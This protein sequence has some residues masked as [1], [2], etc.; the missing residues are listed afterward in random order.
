[1]IYEH[2]NNFYGFIASEIIGPSLKWNSLHWRQQSVE[3]V[4]T[5]SLHLKI[6][7]IKLDGTRDTVPVVF[8]KDSTDI[9][10]LS[11]YV[12]ASVYPKIQL[13]LFARDNIFK[14]SVQLKSWRVYYDPVPECAINPQVGFANNA[15]LQAI[16]QGDNLI[17]KIPIEN[18]LVKTNSHPRNK[19]KTLPLIIPS[20]IFNIK[21]NFSIMIICKSRMS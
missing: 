1:M 14:T 10:D 19:V 11:N 6:V 18:M 5:D 16:Q 17:V 13:V 7:R 8:P 15:S 20:F 12:D 3:T 21:I 2:L 9:Y 4:S